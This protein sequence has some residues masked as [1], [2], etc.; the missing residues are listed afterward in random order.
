MNEVAEFDT[1]REARIA[2]LLTFKACGWKFSEVEARFSGRNTAIGEVC[3]FEVVGCSDE[4]R[5]PLTLCLNGCY[6]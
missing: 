3:K 2:L 6:L 4:S 5:H 1:Y